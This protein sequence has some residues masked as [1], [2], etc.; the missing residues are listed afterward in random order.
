[1]CAVRV[2]RNENGFVLNPN[3]RELE[4]GKLDLYISGY[5][6]NILMIEMRTMRQESN[7]N[8]LSEDELCEAIELAKKEIQ[9]IS[10]PIS[11]AF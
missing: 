2:G 1:M 3:A 9:K 10:W 6:D 8:E 4:E 7:A 5:E 11:K